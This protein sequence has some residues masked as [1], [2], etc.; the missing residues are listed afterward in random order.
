MTSA[1]LRHT[2]PPRTLALAV[3]AV[4]ALAGCQEQ[5]KPVARA[6]MDVAA[7][8]VS[9]SPQEQSVTLTGE[10]VAHVQTNLSFRVSGQVTERFVD[11]GS[12]VKAG[13]VLA[14][15]DPREQ[16]ADVEASA[17][18]L[19]AAEA[20]VRQAGS[21][22]ERQ[23]QLLAQGFTTRRDFDAAET[24][25]RTANGSLEAAKAQLDT[26]RNTLSYTELRAEADGIVTAR[27]AEVGQV[28]QA[29]QTMFTIAQDGPRD[30]VFD[31]YETLLFAQPVVPGINLALV[32]DPSVTAI[33]TVSEMS[34][35]IDVNSGTVRVKL[36]IANPPARMTLGAA[37]TGNARF[38]PIK[39]ARLPWTALS[40]SKGQPAVWV[41]DPADQSVS[42]R[43]VTV[44]SFSTGTAIISGGI[45]DGDV[46]VTEGGK[47]LRPGLVVAARTEAKP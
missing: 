5:A 2:L 25:L 14:R 8:A 36:S 33:G 12:A 15:L 26:A 4:L 38:A 11:V 22:L 34:P 10:V 20:Q 31:V 44:A 3:G 37:V 28:A 39:A 27:T 46:V 41:V 19:R 1:D 17:A 7:Q 42:L 32:S 18:S 21:T 40:S 30:A 35:T 24:A 13:Q 43:P 23:K 16:E 45:A 47:F 29:A 6:P 9:F